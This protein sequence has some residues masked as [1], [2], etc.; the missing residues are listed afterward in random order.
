MK[1]VEKPKRSN[2]GKLP[3]R[4][5]NIFS[6]HIS[7]DCETLSSKIKKMKEK[8]RANFQKKCA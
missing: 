6:S 7:K 5:Q 8:Q 4:Y 3:K 1:Q 2:A